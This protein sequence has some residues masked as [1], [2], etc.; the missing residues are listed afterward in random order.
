MFMKSATSNRKLMIKITYK[1]WMG[2]NFSFCR[3]QGNFKHLTNFSYSNVKILIIP[4]KSPVT[5]STL[6]CSDDVNIAIL[7]EKVVNCFF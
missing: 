5:L 4:L 6:K 7:V 2:K 1:A 3:P